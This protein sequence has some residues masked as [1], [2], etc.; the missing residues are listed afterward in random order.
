VRIAWALG[1]RS[2]TIKVVHFLH[3]DYLQKGGRYLERLC[4]FI[5]L[6]YTVPQLSSAS[7]NEVHAVLDLSLGFGSETQTSCLL[8]HLFFLVKIE[9]L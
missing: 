4:A 7:S 8:R 1:E 2:F 9:M 3:F 6:S 5:G